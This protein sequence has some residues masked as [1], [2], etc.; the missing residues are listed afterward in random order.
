LSRE[1]SPRPDPA[2]IPRPLPPGL[3]TQQL[4]R[5]H[6]LLCLDFDGTLA[7]LTNDPWQAVP[8][9]RAKNALAEL[10]R[11]PAKLTLAI[12]SGRDLDTLLR[13]LGLRE[14]LLFAGTHGLEFVALRPASIAARKI[15]RCCANSS[16]KKFLPIGG[17]SSRINASR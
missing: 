3:I 7:E 2:Q 5:G 15:L 14:G 13:L 12:I 4:L 9:P 1:I 11:Q 8:L 6:L 10:A 17:S 16:G